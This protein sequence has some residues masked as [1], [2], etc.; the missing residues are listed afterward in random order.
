V[1]LIDHRSGRKFPFRCALCAA[2][3]Q[4]TVYVDARVELRC[5]THGLIAGQTRGRP[6]KGAIVPDDQASRRRLGVS[7][8]L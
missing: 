4:P 6:L 7:D 8:I 5:P 3:V 1:S 2:P